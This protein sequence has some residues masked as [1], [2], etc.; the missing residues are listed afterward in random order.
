[1][2]QSGLWK[3]IVVIQRYPQ[4]H[5]INNNT[6]NPRLGIQLI[7]IHQFNFFFS[8]LTSDSLPCPFIDSFIIAYF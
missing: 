1:M 5:H 4:A 7:V 2:I 6:A 8:D 3:I